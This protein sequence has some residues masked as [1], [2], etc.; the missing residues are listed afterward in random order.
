VPH[1]RR[2]GVLLA[3]ALAAC[4]LIGAP[5]ALAQTSDLAKPRSSVLIVLD[6]SQAMGRERLAT[7]RRAVVRAV[8]SLPAGTPVG[9]RVYGGKAAAKDRGAACS[10]S[11]A[12]VPVGAAD[13]KAMSSALADLKPTGLSPVAVALTRAGKDLPPAGDRTIVLVASG[14]DSCAPLPGCQT[15]SGRRQPTRVDAIGFEVNASGRRA[16]DCTARSTGGVYSDA[17]TPDALAAELGA[18]LARATRDRR[19]LGT[20]LVGGVEQSQATPAKPGSYVDSIAPDSER[21]YSVSVP[22]GQ[23]LSVAATLVAPPTGDVSAPGSSLGL[24]TSSGAA[25]GS[26]A[27]VAPTA[28]N[29]FAFDPSRSITVSLTSPPSNGPTSVRVVLHDS[30]DK[31]LA[32]KLAGRSLAL[33][34]LFKQA[35]RAQRPQPRPPAATPAK[36]ASAHDVSLAAAA[37]AAMVCALIAFAS[38]ALAPQRKIADEERA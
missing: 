7:A 1:A 12:L 23:A 30:P 24:S 25:F 27:T 33:E 19:S 22:R 4:A 26:G 18:A 38:L 17:A 11:R 8:R 32:Q 6:A 3:G 15:V 9:L 34:L 29:L 2:K 36:H 5:H 37:A 28:S 13:P 16:L 20:P 21:W 35:P 14:A 10:D 31:Q